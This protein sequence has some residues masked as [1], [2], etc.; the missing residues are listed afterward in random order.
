MFIDSKDLITVELYWKRNEKNR[1]LIVLKE[2]TSLTEDAKKTFT[3][4]TLK[5]R[6]MGWGLYNELQRESTVDKGT[7]D[8]DQLDWIKYK[9]NKLLK[10]LA[11]WD[12]QDKEGKKIPI[13]M[14]SIKT[15]H[16]LIAELALSEYD[17]KSVLGE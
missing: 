2:I 15:L 8:G 9:E 10:L 1:S 6:P 17:T 14:E 12:A 11:D 7:G 4:T 13:N 3:K 5:M 16:P